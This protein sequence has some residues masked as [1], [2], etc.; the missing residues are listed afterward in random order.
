V[1]FRELQLLSLMA[2][3]NAN[4]YEQIYAAMGTT[5]IDGRAYLDIDSSVKTA[6]AVMVA[7]SCLAIVGFATTWGPLAWTVCAEIYPAQYRATCMAIA[8]ASNWT[9]NFLIGFFTPFITASI[10]YSYGFVFA[11]VILLGSSFVYLFVHETKGRSLEAIDQI[12]LNRVKPWRSAGPVV[13]GE[14]YGNRT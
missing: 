5:Y 14:V 11:S 1:S 9:F 7:F 12:I 4:E 3:S 2:Y 13:D 8:T 10:G 6:G